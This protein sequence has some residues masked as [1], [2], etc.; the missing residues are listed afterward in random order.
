[1]N[2]HKYSTLLQNTGHNPDFS[3][4]FVKW[5]FF[6]NNRHL[7]IIN[8]RYLLQF[9]AVKHCPSV[10]LNT[11]SPLIRIFRAIVVLLDFTIQ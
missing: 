2:S 11:P 10:R 1:M 5:K 7:I 9:A 6:E 3:K 4:M 8:R